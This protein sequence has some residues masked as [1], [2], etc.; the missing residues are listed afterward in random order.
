MSSGAAL[1]ATPLLA[2]GGAIALIGGGIWAAGKGIANMA[3]GLQ[4]MSKIDMATIIANIARMSSSVITLGNSMSRLEGSLTGNALENSINN[5]YGMARAANA[6]AGAI[7]N[8]D[9]TKANVMNQVAEG[10]KATVDSAV[11]LSAA[12][13]AVA[14]TQRI[15]AAAARYATAVNEARNLRDP[16]KDLIDTIRT[17]V[18]GEKAASGGGGGRRRGGGSSTVILKMN[19]REFARTVVDV[20]EN[21][22]F[23]LVQG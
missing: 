11:Q 13:E 2:F 7:N 8:I 23:N 19:D 12:P 21:G 14:A 22:E 6:V 17:S 18:T 1:A 10:I 15:A 16:L 20:L 5:L 3:S 9:V 4:V